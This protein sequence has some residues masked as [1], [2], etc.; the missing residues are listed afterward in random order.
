MLLGRKPQAFSHPDWLFELKYDGFRALA[1][2]EDG[3][4]RLMSRNGNQFKSFE[5]LSQALP[6]EVLSRSAIVDGEIVCLDPD[7]RPN[8]H[9][10]FYRRAEPVFVAFD[11]LSATGEDK[12]PLPLLE[13]KVQLQRILRP[14]HCSLFCAHIERDGEALFQLACEHDLEGIVAK[15]SSGPYLAGRERTSW[16]KVRNRSYSQWE[17]RNE[18]FERPE[19]PIVGWENCALA[20]HTATLA[21]ASE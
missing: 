15:H 3:K 10:L 7:G 18:M 5:N 17:A 11:L 6:K 12:R 20:A 1:F 21:K 2:L 19:E 8:F 16:F 13:R 9:N 4:C 14:R